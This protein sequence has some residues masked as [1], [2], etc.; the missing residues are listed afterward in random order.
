M[1]TFVGRTC[2]LGLLDGELERVRQGGE[3][4]FVWMRGRRRVGKS[5]LVQEF[6]EAAKLPYVFYQAPRRASADALER[7]RKALAASTLPVSEVVRAGA[8]FDSWSAALRLA[9]QGATRE[10]PAI[11]V[12]DELPYLVEADA[13]VA[14]DIQEAWDRELQHRPVLLVCIGS[15][16]RMMR[17][18]TE[19]PAELY[20]R[21]TREMIIQP[22]S[23][24][25][26]ATLSGVDSAQAFDRFLIVGGLPMLARSWAPSLT[27]RQFLARE[28]A[29]PASPLVVD[30]LRIL[31]AEFPGELQVRDA[32]GAIGH[33]ERA[34]TEI[35]RR[36][37]V[38]NEAGLS[39]ALKTLVSKGVVASALPYA[40]PPGLKSRR[41]L[42]ADPYLRFWLRFIGPHI[43]E[44]DRGRGDLLL[45]RVERDWTSFRGRAIEPVAR[46]SIERLLP[47]ERFG[48]ARYVGGYWT[49]TNVPEVDL[50]GA[51]ESKPTHV[52]FVGSIKWRENAQFTRRDTE[53][54]IVQRAHVPGAGGARLVGVSRRGFAAGSGLD[55]ELSPD[56]LLRAWPES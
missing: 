24:R 11:V 18:L 46:R 40:A 9:Q 22:F 43:E 28:L 3:G 16:M 25:D 17:A 14:A 27:R 37:G 6:V 44:I 7:F 26:L 50:V 1:T 13:G 54:L 30:G 49:R 48:D 5:R 51:A 56:E 38:A 39:A 29:D 32:L 21:P 8:G 55:V 41:Y 34:F 45:E 4:R 33:G 36:S 53:D 12:I 52:S 35:G 19:Y 47:D 42:V 10:Q 15:D 23:P 20:G 31:D 2:E